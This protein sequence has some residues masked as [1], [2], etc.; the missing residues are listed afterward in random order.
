CECHSACRRGHRVT[1][2]CACEKLTCSNS[3][4]P[5]ECLAASCDYDHTKY[6]KYNSKTQSCMCPCCVSREDPIHQSWCLDWSR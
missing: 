3:R 1:A 5:D 4:G 6:C 2:D